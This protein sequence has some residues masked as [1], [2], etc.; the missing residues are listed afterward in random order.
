M[1]PIRMYYCLGLLQNRGLQDTRVLHDASD[2]SAGTYCPQAR[3]RPWGM[4]DTIG[5]GVYV[6]VGFGVWVGV[7]VSES[8]SGVNVG[9]S[10]GLIGRAV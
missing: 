7:G 9:G 10:V 2:F 3:S 4:E 1:L 8:G 5:A 6:S